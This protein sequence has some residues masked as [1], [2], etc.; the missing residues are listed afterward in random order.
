VSNVYF[1]FDLEPT[2][3]ASF[4]PP[5]LNGR[6]ILLRFTARCS[7]SDDQNSLV[8]LSSNSGHAVFLVFVVTF[9]VINP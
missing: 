4:S 8:S 2:W 5:L 3:F 6:W 9:K 7:L 1:D